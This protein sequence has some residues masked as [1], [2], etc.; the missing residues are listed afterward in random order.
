MSAP[1]FSVVIPLYNKRNAVYASVKS[2]LS[3]TFTDLEVI[4][5]DDGS[6]DD[7][8]SVV[9][10]I[11]DFRVKLCRKKNGGVSSARNYGIE[12]ANGRYI[13]FLDADDTWFSDFLETMKLLIDKYP[14][15]GIYCSS[16]R[17]K[18]PSGLKITFTSAE[19][20]ENKT[21]V[22][23]ENGFDSAIYG[24][25]FTSTIVIPK[26]V[27]G[28]CGMFKFGARMGEDL[29]MWARIMLKY[30]VAYCPIPKVNY[31]MG[32]TVQATGTAKLETQYPLFDTL[33]DLLLKNGVGDSKRCSI[34][35]YMDSKFRETADIMLFARN[36]S[37]IGE[38]CRRCHS[39]FFSPTY[40]KFL[41]NRLGVY[42]L[43]VRVF[44]IRAFRKILR[45]VKLALLG[46]YYERDGRR[47]I[48]YEK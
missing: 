6:T 45:I 46:R 41:K 36:F 44:C 16:M 25:F 10:S 40:T 3:Q 47:L 8:A 14:Q 20:S 37:D 42:I 22:L 24:Y 28:E 2:V 32:E 9:E 31:I 1:F 27:F 23:I 12:Q 11:D 34:M 30:S 4:V 15:C 19:Y 7:S 39:D 5:V 21:D 43:F 17:I 18:F 26:Q 38:L 29:D 48:V 33:Y 35:K 13:A